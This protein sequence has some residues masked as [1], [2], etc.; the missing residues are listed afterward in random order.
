[1]LCDK[2]PGV[3]FRLG[4]EEAPMP[5]CF[6]CDPDP[7]PMWREPAPGGWEFEDKSNGGPAAAVAEMVA[8]GHWPPSG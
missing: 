7:Q 1:M 5:G 4:T 2:H 8:S 6:V 3:T